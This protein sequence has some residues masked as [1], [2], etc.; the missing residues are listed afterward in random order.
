MDQFDN[1]TTDGWGA[2]WGDPDVSV[3]APALEGSGA[4]QVA[5]R[6]RQVVAV[7][8][9]SETSSLKTGSSITLHVEVVHG[10]RVTITPY[11][12]DASGTSHM[13]E[14]HDIDSADGWVQIIFAV[15]PVDQVN[16]VGFQVWTPDGTSTVAADD[17]S[18]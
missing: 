8:T 14:A 4:L 1:G 5:N 12:K 13:R 6:G 15:P 2:S 11:V 17:I 10:S 3:G 9:E 16:A 18:W 7:E